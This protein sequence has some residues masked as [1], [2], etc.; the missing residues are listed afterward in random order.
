MQQVLEKTRDEARKRK[1]RDGGEV[2]EPLG[3][4]EAE[5]ARVKRNK[6]VELRLVQSWKE[7]V[8]PKVRCNAIRVQLDEEDPPKS[9]L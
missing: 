3:G 2:V 1:E 5:E 7:I 4:E 6:N 8:E 9:P